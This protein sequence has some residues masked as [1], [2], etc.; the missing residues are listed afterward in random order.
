ML[1]FSSSISITSISPSQNLLS[2]TFLLS[3]N[4]FFKLFFF[5]TLNLTI[6]SKSYI[7]LSKNQ[8]EG[9]EPSQKALLSFSTL[10]EEG[11]KNKQQD[12][13]YFL[14]RLMI[15]LTIYNIVYLLIKVK[16]N[17]NKIMIFKKILKLWLNYVR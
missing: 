13:F 7:V 11:I 17:I 16:K 10:G 4:I 2:I 1:P 3:S 6:S 5:K 14:L 15:N 9:I 12:F 8:K